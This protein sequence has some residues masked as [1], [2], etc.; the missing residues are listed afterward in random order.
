MDFNEYFSSQNI[1]KSTAE[2]LLLCGHDEQKPHLIFNASRYR[3]ISEKEKEEKDRKTTTAS[4]DSS[5]LRTP[6]SLSTTISP[7]KLVGTA[8]W[9][10][11]ELKKRNGNSNMVQFQPSTS[12][13]SG[14]SGA[15]IMTSEGIN[16]EEPRCTS[17][18]YPQV[19]ASSPFLFNSI[20]ESDESNSDVES[21]MN[22]MPL[23]T[24]SQTTQTQT[25]TQT[26]FTQSTI[27]TLT[28]TQSLTQ[29]QNLTFRSH[30]SDD[31]S[32]TRV[33]L[34]HCL[35]ASSQFTSQDLPKNEKLFGSILTGTRFEDQDTTLQGDT[36]G[37]S[38]KRF[39]PERFS[40]SSLD[41]VVDTDE[42]EVNPPSSKVNFPSSSSGL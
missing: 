32:D 42:L 1:A 17:D 6:T 8:K 20:L 3:R 21:M 19:Q 33:E 9:L 24:Q 36:A 10:E 18:G 12:S 37:N 38:R 22:S 15:I 34:W 16:F 29:K 25:Q 35:D 23:L 2:L 11:S 7:R 14:V 5:S 26:A 41:M 13:S 30:D 39:C 31:G 28:E 27:G 4:H 40:S